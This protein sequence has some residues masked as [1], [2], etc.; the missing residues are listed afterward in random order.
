MYM[1]S[2]Y[3]SYATIERLAT[4]GYWLPDSQMHEAW[5]AQGTSHEAHSP[6]PSSLPIVG[7]EVAR[8]EGSVGM[9]FAR[10]DTSS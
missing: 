6:V 7:M 2:H 8:T 9:D 3:K 1:Y 4:L 10:M 5:V